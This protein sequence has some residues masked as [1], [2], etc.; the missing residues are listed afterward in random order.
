MIER[1]S[2]VVAPYGFDRH[3]VEGS[4]PVAVWVAFGGFLEAARSGRGPF[5]LECLTH[6]RRGHYE[7][8]AEQYRDPLEEAQWRERDPLSRL[9]ERALA[10]GW[11]GEDQARAIEA[12]ARAA[13]DAAVEFARASPLPEPEISAELVYAR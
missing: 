10:D 13:V 5:L 7:G 1:V 2:D 6:R 3:T 4:D 11:I 12:E 9:Q 8:D